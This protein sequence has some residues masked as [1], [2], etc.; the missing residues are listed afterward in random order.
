VVVEQES[1]DRLRFTV[2][3]TGIGIAPEHQ[4]SIFDSFTQA[5]T[6]TTRRFG[7]S[8]LG[9]A[10]CKQLVGL[11]GGE[12]GI[13]SAQ[14]QGSSF[15][16][17]VPCIAAAPTTAGARP[18]AA[19]PATGRGHILIVEDNQTNRVVAA[20]MLRLL[21]CTSGTAENGTVAITAW[22]SGD[23]DLILMDCNM[24]E[25]DGYQAT[26]SIRRQ[27]APS[28][29]R[30]PIIAM[31]A[32][33]QAVD[34]EKCLAAGMDDHLAK[35]LTLQGLA[36]KL[37][38]WLD[39]PEAPRSEIPEAQE[40]EEQLSLDTSVLLRLQE[41]LGNSIG[42][43]IR[44]FL[45]DMPGYLVEMD[46]AVA[47]GNSTSLRQVAHIIKGAAGNLGASAVAGLAKEIELHAEAGALAETA[48][49]VT[50][51]RTEFALVEPALNTHLTHAVQGG[52]TIVLEDAPLVLVVDDDRS[53]RSALR[54]VLRRSGFRVEEAGDGDE[55]LA[56]LENSTPDAILMDALMPV[57]DGFAACMALKKHPRW[58]DIPVLMITA[59]EDR[60]SIEKAFEAGA[61]DFIPKPIHLSVVN[62]RVRRIID[63]TRAERHVRHLAYS[64]TLTGLPNRAL[65]MDQLNRSIERIAARNGMIAILFLDLD[66]FKYVNDTLGHEVGDR[67]LEAMA[68]R[69]KGCVRNDDCVARLGGDEFT[70]LLEDIPNPGV[71][72]S[73]AQNIC[74]TVSAPLEIDGQEI[75]VTASIGISV[76]PTDGL[77]VSSLLRHADTA[78]YRAKQNRSGF[79]YY[80][81]TME[82][83]MAERVQLENSLRRAL[84]RD[85]ITV[86]YQPVVDTKSG[87]IA[88]VEALVR[89]RHPVRGIVSPMEF[90]PVAEETGLILA[91]GERV[92]R[93][94]CFQTKVW[95]DSGLPLQRVA[96]NLSA[97]QLEQEDLCEVVLAALK[98][99][100]LPADVLILEITE[101]VLM[102]QARDPASILHT[103]RGLGVRISIDDFG[104]GYSSLAYLKHLPADYLKIDRSFIKD[105]PDDADAVAIVTGIMTLAHSLR[106]TVVAEGVETE[107][108][109]DQLAKL[110]C[111][112]LQGYLFSKPVPAE[113]LETQLLASPPKRPRPRSRK[114]TP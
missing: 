42:E 11:L 112:Y 100:G 64:D 5:D 67:L 12:I 45:E 59:L 73:V 82:S 29:R 15:W 96:V 74:R 66:R 39:W 98:D 40:P 27:E 43:A 28:G 83:V 37:R 109:R 38:H 16:F 68:Q 56:W 105:I 91:L 60:Q 78:M 22:Q 61:S 48:E 108:Q 35:P 70:I 114:K 13:S 110:D 47:E 46:A 3:D 52:E 69:I 101:S 34:I 63:A 31:T 77:D 54:H 113:L 50:R 10:I 104:T 57:M 106:L 53:T 111:D 44:P 25:T 76:Y 1:A 24:P 18:G 17:T 36:A 94:A 92:L 72:G 9:L 97:K 14:D 89:W 41:A 87:V 84:E 2:S 80:E 90:I 26:A 79:S 81:A 51:L 88:S 85:E 49:L 93:T 71:A 95:L 4:A 20:G 7:G 30:I 32:N 86:F 23:W 65:F 33:T 58:K 62:Q 6:S 21:G 75:F 107:P 103:L 19:A 99:S 8:G 102:E 55:A